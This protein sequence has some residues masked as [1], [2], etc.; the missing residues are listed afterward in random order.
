MVYF[1]DLYHT[2]STDVY[3]QLYKRISFDR[4]RRSCKFTVFHEYFSFST[5]VFIFLQTK[6]IG[7]E[8]REYL[9]EEN[10]HLTR[11]RYLEAF[12]RNN[13][14]RDDWGPLHSD[15]HY[16]LY[17]HLNDIASISEVDFDLTRAS[18]VARLDNQNFEAN[19][20]D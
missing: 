2:Y 10:E 19:V 6:S 3:G 8:S 14:P 4:T 20:S 12:R 17:R 16:G 11:P 5:L 7:P 1:R 18:V 13:L 9:L 15:D